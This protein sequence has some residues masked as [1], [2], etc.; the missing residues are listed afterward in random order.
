MSEASEVEFGEVLGFLTDPKLEVRQFAAEGV[1]EQTD[2]QDFLDF[3]RRNPRKAAKPLL[4]LAEKAEADAATAHAAADAAA[5]SKHSGPGHEKAIRQAEME[6]MQNSAAGSAALQAL[7]NLSAIPTVRDELVELSAPRRILDA[8]RSGWLEGRSGQ[9]HWYSML[10]ANMT[11]GTAGQ[12][13]VCAD[14]SMFRFVLSAYVAKPRPEPRDGYD[15]P[16]TFLG[17]VL[18]NTCA[19]ETGRRIL[20]H[21]EGGGAT[22]VMLVNELSDRGRRQDVMG[23][24]RNLCLDTECHAALVAANPLW[25]MA[26]FLYP[27]EKASAEHRGLLPEALAQS[28][29]EKGAVMTGEGPVRHAGAICILGLCRTKEGREYLREAG[30]VE[31]L[32]AWRAEEPLED[33]QGALDTAEVPLKQTEEELEK[34]AAQ[35]AQAPASGWLPMSGD[36][37]GAAKETPAE[38]EPTGLFEAP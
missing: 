3:V 7:V 11:T 10:L 33:V 30:V 27:W 29:S 2:S 28:L 6:A 4:R 19:L 1:L 31:L 36:Q 15:D 37:G 23:A 5:A 34:E 32:R 26:Q 14:E 16:L 13:A 12:E 18:N 35:G 38:G 8:M 22:A 24:L 21:G 20:T 9:A 17:K 25:A